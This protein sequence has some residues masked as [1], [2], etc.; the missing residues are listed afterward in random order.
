MTE[1]TSELT[2]EIINEAATV[3]A[4]A[5]WANNDRSLKI[6]VTNLM[7]DDIAIGDYVISVKKL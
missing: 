2:E 4:Y 5:C 7:I 3:I 6:T 1:E